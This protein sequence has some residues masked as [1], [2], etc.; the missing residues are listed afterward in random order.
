M[1]VP[2][3]AGSLVDLAVTLRRGTSC[4]AVAEALRLAAEGELAPILGVEEQELV[5]RPSAGARPSSTLP[6]L[7]QAGDHLPGGGLVRQHAATPIGSPSCN[8]AAARG[9]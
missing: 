5:S 2:I 7:Q 6:L 9:A 8:T 4:A 1:R 3:V